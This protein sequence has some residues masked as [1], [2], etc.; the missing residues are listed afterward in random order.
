MCQDGDAS[1]A[2]AT[3]VTDDEIRLGTV[4]DKGFTGVPGLN[5]EMYD[6][7]VAFTTWCNEHGGILG[8][9]LV[10][11]DLDAALTEYEADDRR[12][13]RRTSPSSAAAPCSTTTR[14]TCG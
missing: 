7:A 9:E 14:T 3:G 5:K 12:R 13:A 8:R 2:T 11:D 6:A 1:G 10:L 4:T